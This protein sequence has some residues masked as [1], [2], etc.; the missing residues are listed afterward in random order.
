MATLTAKIKLRDNQPDV[1][2]QLCSRPLPLV[3]HAAAEKTQ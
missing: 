1:Q 3:T 2:Q